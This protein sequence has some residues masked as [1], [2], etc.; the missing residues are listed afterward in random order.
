[1][2]SWQLIGLS[3]A[4]FDGLWPN[5]YIN[6]YFQESDGNKSVISDDPFGENDEEKL[7]A[8][9]KSFENKYN[10]RML[11]SKLRNTWQMN[12]TWDDSFNILDE[13]YEYHVHHIF[14]YSSYL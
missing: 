2:F 4:N 6:I 10:V 3:F 8:I 11:D 1:M 14:Y 13:L 7:K 9:A 12:M 5:V